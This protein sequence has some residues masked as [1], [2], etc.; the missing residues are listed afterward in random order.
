MKGFSMGMITVYMTE[1]IALECEL[2]VAEELTYTPNTVQQNKRTAERWG[3]QVEKALY[4]PWADEIP[5][6]QANILE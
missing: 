5:W 6:M 2:W 3:T 4:F 1:A